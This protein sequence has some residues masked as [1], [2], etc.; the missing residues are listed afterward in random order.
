MIIRRVF[1]TGV[2]A[3]TIALFTGAGPEPAVFLA[4]NGT[5]RVEDGKADGFVARNLDE[6]GT[7]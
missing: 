4:K 5:S 7:V 1:G 6:E 3:D 2:A